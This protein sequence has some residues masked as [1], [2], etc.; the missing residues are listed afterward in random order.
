MQL[1]RRVSG[2]VWITARLFSL[3][4]APAPSF[5]WSECGARGPVARLANVGVDFVQYARQA[6]VLTV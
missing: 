2:R 5:I 4:F 3:V 1:D 6:S